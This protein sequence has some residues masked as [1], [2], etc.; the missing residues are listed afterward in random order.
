MAAGSGF[1]CFF[2]A[3]SQISAFLYGVPDNGIIGLR[4]LVDHARHMAARSDIPILVDADT[5]Y[6]NAVNV[7][8]RSRRSSAPAWPRCRSRIRRRRRNPAPPPG[9]AAFR[10]TKRSARSGPRSAA[11]DALDPEFVDLRALRRA[12]RRRRQFRG[13]GGALHRLCRRRRRRSD[14]AQLGRDARAGAKRAC[15]EIPGPVLRSGA[16][17]RRRRPGRNMKSS[18]RASCSIRP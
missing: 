18:A 6:G 17:R 5:G 12:R 4:D 13:S 9:D 3:G 14:L 15:K 16:A 10:S 8:S 2:L 7:H 1:R 11:R